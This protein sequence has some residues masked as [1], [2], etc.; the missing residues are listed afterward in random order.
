MSANASRT[1]HIKRAVLAGLLSVLLLCG[2]SV[3]A[4]QSAPVREVHKVP[5]GEN[6][7]CFFVEKNVVLTPGEIAAI[8][9]DEDLTKE[10]L[11][12]A[13]LYMSLSSC[14]EHP[15]IS[16]EEWLEAGNTLQLSEIDIIK[17]RQA[18]PADGEPVKLHLDLRFTVKE[19]WEDE[20]QPEPGEDP[21]VDPPEDPSDEPGN[22]PAVDPPDDPGEDSGDEPGDGTGDSTGDE[23][24][25]EPGDEPGSG[26]VDSTGD[27]PTVDPP[28]N[29]DEDP[30]ETPEEDPVKKR[31]VYS[32]FKKTSPELLFIV[33]AT[34]GDA[35]TAEDTCE[36]ESTPEE[37]AAPQESELPELPELPEDLDLDPDMLSGLSEPSEMLPELRTIKMTDKSGAPVE[38]TLQDGD[39]VSL[40]WI[41][42]NKTISKSDFEKF[43]ERFPGG[44]AGL[45]ALLGIAAVGIGVAAVVLRR[46]KKEDY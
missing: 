36:A 23:P 11:Q 35:S 7:Y 22:D 1:R 17:L 6:M 34:E 25:S 24:G 18:A 9:S 29:P 44:A 28:D 39:P 10:V 38:E 14:Q 2:Q 46:K 41:E 8:E 40:E 42:P 5:A 3:F 37:P 45:G 19:P 12:R 33:I 15:A 16:M 43:L 4:A 27:A 31:Q 13:G 32:T 20:V 26:S 30:A 21:A